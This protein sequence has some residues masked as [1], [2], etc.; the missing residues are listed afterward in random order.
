V[1]FPAGW[2]HQSPFS[3]RSSTCL[4]LRR[5]YRDGCAEALVV[6]RTKE[7][8]MGPALGDFLPSPQSPG[9]NASTGGAKENSGAER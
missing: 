7:E 9:A 4:L 6:P 1:A 5:G 3:A 2:A 8:G